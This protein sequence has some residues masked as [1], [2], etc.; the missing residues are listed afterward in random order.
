[1]RLYNL[2]PTNTLEQKLIEEIYCTVGAHR[3]GASVNL[4][5]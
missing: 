3:S 1:L 5:C 4:A 2:A